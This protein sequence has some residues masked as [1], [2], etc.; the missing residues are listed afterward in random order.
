MAYVTINPYTS[1]KIA[2]FSENTDQEI[3]LALDS[4]QE[5][6]ESW[7]ERS[8]AERVQV[9]ARAAR[10]MRER[11]EQYA[12]LITLEMGKLAREARA[13][14]DLSARII[15]YYVTHSERLLAPQSL[16][17]TDSLQGTPVLYQEPLGVLLAIEPW[18]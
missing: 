2:E 14:V 16:P 11:E 15:D 13:E 5:A 18:N 1:E 7:R 17:V 10:L 8:V 12:Q 9:L 6:F 4:A 3:T